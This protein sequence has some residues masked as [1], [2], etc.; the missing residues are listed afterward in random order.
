MDPALRAFRD[1]VRGPDAALDLARAA[2]AVAR[3]EHPDLDE[4]HEMARLDALATRVGTARRAEAAVALD[5]LKRLLFQEEGFRGNADEYYDPRNSCLNDVLDRKLGI[6]ITLSVLMMEVGRR[7]GLDIAG[8][9]LPG[10]FIV[11][12]TVGG[13]SILLDPFHG[14][15]ELTPAAAADVAARAVG[16]PVKLEESHWAPC[17]RR[18]IV[19]R[20][21]RNLKTTYARRSDWTRALGVIDRLLLI[22]ADVPMHLRDRG[23][24]L[25]RSGRLTEG[26]AEWESYL[27]RYPHAQDAEAFRQE[28][29]RVRQE[30]GSRN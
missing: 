23:T 2:L 1:L 13:R 19:V 17:T 21:L 3:I 20:M 14:G 5:R 15:T 10:H 18:Q 22:D 6:P 29:R 8:V 9:G 28:L 16:R 7:V 26:A 25:V 24:V 12:A 30:L 11:S 27:S 4:S